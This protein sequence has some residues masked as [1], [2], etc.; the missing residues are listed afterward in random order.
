V[1]VCQNSTKSKIHTKIITSHKRD[2]SKIKQDCLLIYGGSTRECVHLVKSLHF[3]S[4]D[5]GSQITQII[6]STIPQNPMPHANLMVLSFLE[7]K[8]WTM[9]VYVAGIGSFDLFCSCD[10]DLDPVTFIYE[11]ETYSLE[12]HQIPMSRLSKVIVWQTHK[13][14]VVTS[15]HITKT[16]VTPFDLPYPKTPCHMQTSWL[17]FLEPELWATKVLHCGKRNFQPFCSCDLDLD[18]DLMNFIYELNPYSW[19]IH[20]MCKYDLHTSRLWKG[21]V[22]QTDRQVM[23]GHYRSRDRDGGHTIQSVIPANPILHANLMALSF[24]EPELSAIKV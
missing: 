7:P 13:S 18:L 5:N 1:L 10:L 12:T 15:S 8:L 11:L 22:W 20:R 21:T 24:I 9:K 2:T 6:R 14:R 19:E 17:S 16:A 3:W 23:H 4:R